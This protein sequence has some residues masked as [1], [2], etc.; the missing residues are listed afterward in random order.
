MNITFSKLIMNTH[1]KHKTRGFVILIIPFLWVQIGL[2]AEARITSAQFAAKA[3]PVLPIEQ[4]RDFSK[5]LENWT[6][7][8]RRD[9][10]AKPLGW[11]MALPALGWSILIPADAGPV[12]R[13]A[14]E[15]FRDYLDRAMQ[16][17]VALDTRA[18][19]EGWQTMTRAI[20]A[21]TRAQ[22]SGC[23]TELQ[24]RKDYQIMVTPDRI[25]VCGFDDRGAMYGLY[26]IEERMNLREAPFLPKDLNTVRRSLFGARMTLSGLG[27]EEWPD[28]YLSILSHY[29]FDSIYASVYANPNGVVAGS[30][31][32]A[33]MKRQDPA[34]THDLIRRAARYGLDLYCPIIH[35]LDDTP[36]NEAALRKLVRDIATEFPEIRG[37]VLLI[38][39]FDYDGWPGW[40]R[41]DMRDWVDHWSRGVNVAAEEFHKINPAIEVLAWDYNIDFRPSALDLKRYVI[42]TYAQDVIP[43]VTWENGKDF[44]RDGEHG[45][46]KDYAINEAG[47]AEVSAAQIEEARKRRLKV[48]AKADCFASWQ[49]GTFP[50]LPIPYQWKERYDGLEKYRIDGTMESWSYGFKPNFAA[51]LRAWYSWSDA[52]PLDD[53][54]RAIARREF[55]PHSEKLALA[56][57][58]H[59]SK[60]IRLV[61]DT[62]PNMGVTNSIGAPF[63]FQK[64]KPRAIVVEHSWARPGIRGGGVPV[65]E[66]WPYAPARVILLPDFTNRTNAAARYASP[67]SLPVFNKYLLLAADEMEKGLTSYR[68]A[69]LNAPPNKRKG[70]FREVLL[71]EQLQRMMR[72]DEAIL[73]FEDLRLKLAKAED[74]ATRRSTLDR[75]STILKEELARTQAARETQLR[76]SR[77]G[78]E[79]EQDYFYTPNVL[80][81]KIQEIRTAL[82][83]EIPAYRK[84]HGLQ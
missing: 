54:L 15:D 82:E 52:P 24:G 10:A 17:R 56:A 69:A 7:P 74:A 71:A 38:E 30:P 19:L 25:V 37:Y 70:A 12:L 35:H 3:L 4:L 9:P 47:P 50:Y 78:Y 58:E 66:Y 44:V 61:P 13:Q 20:I 80:G 67:F 57:W 6:E 42:T 60:A 73:E 49:Y 16:V 63:F 59:F 62:G 31:S 8:L 77:L 51:E 65:S 72:S 2:G 68:Q 22:L 29:G 75:M 39:G 40:N 23:G 34:Y 26:N 33:V 83:R 5:V 48:Y 27:W 79:W 36:E 46:L 21:G 81:E 28:R 41:N 53:L 43:L 45:Y 32:Y 55:G 84:Q 14:A 64:P 18:S 11:E 76:D 1:H